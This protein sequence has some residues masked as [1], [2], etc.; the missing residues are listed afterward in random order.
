MG[1]STQMG[2]VYDVATATAVE[3]LQE[4][5]GLRRDG[6]AGEETLALLDI[7]EKGT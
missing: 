1:Y 4:D 5:F 7:I 2:G 3:R 6:V